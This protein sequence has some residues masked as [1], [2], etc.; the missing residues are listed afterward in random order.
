MNFDLCVSIISSML[1]THLHVTV[2]WPEGQTDERILVT[3]QKAA[4]YQKS[5]RIA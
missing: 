4:L 1:L 2:D 3:F 5:G